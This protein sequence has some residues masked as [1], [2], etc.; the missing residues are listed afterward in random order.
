[1]KRL[2]ALAAFL[3]ARLAVHAQD[4]VLD[5]AAL[6]NY[7]KQPIPFYITRDNVQ[8]EN[9]ISD[10]GATLGRVLFYDKRLS[11]N[12]TVSCASCHQ[13]SHG[14]SD[15]SVASTGVAGTTGRHAMRL[16]NIRFS[17]DP[18]YFWD[19]R[20]HTL[21]TQTTQPI[22]DAVEMGFSGT[23]GDPTVPDLIGKLSATSE[24]PILFE[25]AFGSSTISEG[26][27]QF[28]IAQFVRSIQSFDSRY[29]AGRSSVSS[30]SQAFSNFTASENNGKHLFLT[31]PNQGGVGCAACH[32]PPEFDIDPDSGNNGVIAAI[33]GGTDLT[34]KKAPSLR[35]LA[36]PDG[37]LN[38]PFMHNG[39]FINIAQVIDHYAAIPGDNQFL[40]PR[41]RR[42]DGGVQTLNLTAQER[43]D[44]E[45]FLLTLSGNALYTDSKWSNPFSA[46]G[47]IT[48]RNAPGDPSP[49]PSPTAAPSAP[50]MRNVSTRLRI[51]TGDNVAIG[52]F[53]I[54]GS[55][56]KKVIVRALGPSL[57]KFGVTDAL[58]DPFL[59]LHR[60]DGVLV[61]SNNNWRETQETQITATQL[62]PTDDAE[63]AIV[64]TLAPGA[65][66]AVVGGFGNTSGVGLVEVYDLD[67]ASSSS[68]L[69]NLSTRGHVLA[70]NNVI[71][72]GLIIGGPTPVQ[73]V[74]RAIGPSL[75]A[76]GISDFLQDPTLEL[77]NADGALLFS[78][79][80]WTDD[81]SQSAELS[82]LGLA[83]TNSKESAISV[84]LSAG[85]YTAIVQ[86]K[87]NTTG[88]ALVE[89][90]QIP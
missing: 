39:A 88:V 55:M 7:A 75:A 60:S 61:T 34:N 2:F 8:D 15:P 51:E 74:V 67:D 49:T 24:Y 82:S 13:Q 71:I 16:S 70:A 54:T 21:E 76:S 20:I 17:E 1:M 27:I 63:S 41:L 77:R 32:R 42:P 9:P 35:N 89:V 11:R 62:Q 73:V 50:G 84:Q 81:P 64:A 90:Y 3:A 10:E 52:G 69:A 83:P 65:Y 12:N 48:L 59:E 22:R 18:L 87:A 40:D 79:D 66:T 6:P 25:L 29:D 86:G 38:G 33:G 53:I 78:N 80:N 14:F 68:V 56:S 36:R 44:L 31:P 43:L 57:A 47:T 72:G 85:L 30:D 58:T 37:Q 28:A 4:G 19:E 23:G 26:R 5:L 45:A 46:A